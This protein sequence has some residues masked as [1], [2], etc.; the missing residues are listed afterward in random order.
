M[1]VL[2]DISLASHGLVAPTA[3]G[4]FCL[5]SF[6]LASHGIIVLEVDLEL[7]KL[8][9]PSTG[10]REPWDISYYRWKYRKRKQDQPE[11]E[12]EP[13]RPSVMRELLERDQAAADVAR[14][15]AKNAETERDILELQ[16]YIREVTQGIES[17]IAAELA[18]QELALEDQ[19]SLIAALEDNVVLAREALLVAMEAR[20]RHQNQLAAIEAVI[21][22]YY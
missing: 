16:A 17:G 8:A 19:Q 22:F 13:E 9:D 18:A 14:L 21:R 10:Y 3:G 7:G 1:Y 20:R 12:V 6:P 5:A 11:P 2:N 4:D 15:Q